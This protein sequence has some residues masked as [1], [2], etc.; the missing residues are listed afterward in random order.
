MN[1]TIVDL[2]KVIKVSEKGHNI[3]DVQN[4]LINDISYNNFKDLNYLSV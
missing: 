1:K 4:T 3:L 2:G